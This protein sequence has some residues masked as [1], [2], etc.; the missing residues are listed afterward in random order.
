MATSTIKL[1]NNTILRAEKNFMYSESKQNSGFANFLE[2][3]SK[4]KTVIND[5]QYI[6]HG[7]NIFIKVNQDQTQINKTNTS[8]WTYCSIKNS[9]DDRTFYYYVIGMS[10]KAQK[11][12]EIQLSMDTIATFWSE[13]QSNMKDDTTVQREHRDRFY[14][15]NGE[16]TTGSKLI[17]KID[18]ISEGIQIA[19]KRLVNDK[20]INDISIPTDVTKWYFIYR[21]EV[22]ANE[23]NNNPIKC[24]LCANKDLP[25]GESN[26]TFE[27]S[28]LDQSKVYLWPNNDNNT[29]INK[30]IAYHRQNYEGEQ[31]TY[32]N[33]HNYC[34]FIA[35]DNQ[36][37]LYLRVDG[38][39]N[40]YTYYLRDYIKSVNFSECYSM[41][42]TYFNSHICNIYDINNNPPEKDVLIN[43]GDNRNAD[44]ILFNNNR[45]LSID[46]V[47]RTD[48]RLN[49]I[50]E[51]P[52]CPDDTI[53]HY[54]NPER[55]AYNRDIWE[56][57]GATKT[58]RLIDLNTSFYR[59]LV[60]EYEVPDLVYDVIE[61][62]LYPGAVRNDKLESKIYHSDFS[63]LQYIY[64]NFPIVVDRERLI[65]NEN[66]TNDP[67]YQL[68]Y[69][70]A[71][72]LTSN[73]LFEVKESQNE[74]ITFSKIANHE[75]IA[76][77]NRNNEIPVYQSA[78]LNY[79]R[80]GY[81]YDKKAQS[82]SNNQLAWNTALNIGK[83]A[84]SLGFGLGNLVGVRKDI[85]DLI[86]NYAGVL[87]QGGV[88]I[89]KNNNISVKEDSKLTYRDAVGL[90]S[91]YSSKYDQLK[92]RKFGAGTQLAISNTSGLVSSITNAVYTIQSQENS[93][94]QKLAELSAQSAST[95]GSND[96][97]L[98][99]YYDKNKLH[100]L[101]YELSEEAK[102]PIYDLFYYLGYTTNIQKIPDLYSRSV[103]NYIMATPEFDLQGGVIFNDY[104]LD[105]KARFASGLTIWH[106]NN[107]Y[108]VNNT[109]K[110]IVD[111]LPEE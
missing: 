98:F 35:F 60:Q 105:I 46:N 40:W 76:I 91:D 66:N 102:E 3:K 13:I 19:N 16:I 77:S 31:T 65:V 15:V 69:K 94:N 33:D 20:I 6:R 106:S 74:K 53:Y 80:T 49:M 64:D 103:F 48:S 23:L 4:S 25:I 18:P 73:L 1:Y 90:I 27:L 44:Q 37:I 14:K 87:L 107:K 17:R 24:Y 78:Y 42:L 81:N 58:L 57:S 11:T 63:Q 47:D 97:D 88:D 79:M 50:I 56:Y 84:V 83:S 21:T 51:L 71:N 39:D 36:W 45:I 92:R 55:Y 8:Q 29:I 104:L 82:I 5:F 99:N 93:M 22:N 12:I 85:N 61:E 96:L 108:G 54:T 26:D 32:V 109:E 34:P 41:P 52:Y 62:E 9:D 10:W 110:W 89:D 68:G 86:T 70:Q 43:I 38:S 30:Y 67:T 75:Y 7:L 59:T 95:S 72:N 100:E 101:K 111:Q 2:N 28:E